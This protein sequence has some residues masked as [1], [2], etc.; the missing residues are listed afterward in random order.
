MNKEER[1][2]IFTTF[3]N[4]FSF[5]LLCS[6]F[7]GLIIMVLYI[8]TALIMMNLDLNSFW[9]LIIFIVFIS[10]ICGLI[11]PFIYSYFTCNF[12]LTTPNRDQVKF[13]SFLK[14]SVLGFYRPQRGQLNIWNNLLVS[15]L[16]FLVLSSIITSLSILI[17]YNTNGSA[18]TVLDEI[19]KATD[20]NDQLDLMYKNQE[21]F[22]FPVTIANFVSLLV[23]AYYFLHNISVNIFKY[24]FALT[25]WGN[26][27]AAFK[28]RI[29]K[30]AIKEHRKDF[31]KDY[32]SVSWILFVVFLIGM[33]ASYFGLYFAPIEHLNTMILSLT[34]ISITLF[35]LLPF[36]PLLFD[37]Y[38]V[39]YHRYEK[40]F[41]SS[42][43]EVLKASNEINRSNIHT[44]QDRVNFEEYEKRVQDIEDNVKDSIDKNDKKED[45]DKK[46][47]KD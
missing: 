44:E 41:L 40:Y 13:K 3:K 45:E 6:A 34:A 33:S 27:S 20:F 17:L 14:T 21:M 10:L 30:I 12:V 15:T 24:A 38:L 26:I 1:K 42:F 23:A 5:T 43:I 9:G 16:I 4:N 32:F 39:L 22:S 37:L 19:M 31:Y 7:I 47:K 36:L 46:D 25:N 35:I 2:S 11:A 29:F 18:K 28:N 8:I